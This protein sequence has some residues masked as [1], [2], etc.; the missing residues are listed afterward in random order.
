MTGLVLSKPGSTPNFA[1]ESPNP[2]RP[3][4][5]LADA[6]PMPAPP[7]LKPPVNRRLAIVM[8][9]VSLIAALLFVV[10]TETLWRGLV[11]AP[12][13][14]LLAGGCLISIIAAFITRDVLIAP[15][16][17]FAATAAAD[18]L[19]ALIRDWSYAE[20]KLMFLFA[21]GGSIPALII[22]LLR[23]PSPA[24]ALP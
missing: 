3:P 5:S 19:V 17:C 9:T 23:R 21:C 10:T 1:M 4:Q 20:P 15:L 7:N 16:C 2:Y 13:L 24:R 8:L 11:P 6:V 18:I 14:F 22:A 12:G